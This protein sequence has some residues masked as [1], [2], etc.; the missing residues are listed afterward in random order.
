MLISST[1][2]TSF[3][4]DASFSFGGV[5]NAISLGA[6]TLTSVTAKYFKAKDVPFVSPAPSTAGGGGF[7]YIN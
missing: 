3:S 1:T 4:G 7:L 6:L 5:I 2:F